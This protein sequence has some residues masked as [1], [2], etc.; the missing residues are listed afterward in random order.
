MTSPGYEGA[1]VR[2]MSDLCVKKG[3]LGCENQPTGFF[4]IDKNE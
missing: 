3:G 1:K 4:L 2:E